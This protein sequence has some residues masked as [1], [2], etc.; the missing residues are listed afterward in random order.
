[1][2][3]MRTA[4]SANLIRPSARYSSLMMLYAC[5]DF[6]FS[7]SLVPQPKFFL[8]LGGVQRGEDVG[9]GQGFPPPRALS[10]KG[11]LA[12]GIPGQAELPS[13]SVRSG[14]LSLAP[15]CDGAA[16]CCPQPK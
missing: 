3:R 5:S 13:L 2:K 7:A 10:W 15:L 6:R 4:T 16:T 12:G 14:P 11:H 1:M 9:Q 8:K